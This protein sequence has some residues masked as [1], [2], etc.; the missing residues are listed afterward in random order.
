MQTN[1]SYSFRSRQPVR[2]LNIRTERFRNSFFPFCLSQWNKL[3][4]HIQDMP[5]IASFKR[6]LLNFF[7]PVPRPVF[8]CRDRLGVI[9]LTRLRVGL[10]HLNEHKFRHNFLDTIDPFCNCRAGAIENTEHYLLHC[11]NFTNE[12][13]VLFNDLKNISAHVFPFSSDVLCN[14][15]L[16]GY[17]GLNNDDNREVISAVL[18][19]VIASGRFSGSLLN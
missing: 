9:H 12:R 4:C 11:P 6:S 13:L 17:P 15:L 5:S 2:Q 10:S 8:K 14:L 3:D 7:R 16:Y 18:R 19:Y 1:I